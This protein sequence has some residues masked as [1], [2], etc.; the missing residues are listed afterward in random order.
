MFTT[1]NQGEHVMLIAALYLQ[2]LML[3]EDQHS[4][5]NFPA[6]KGISIGQQLNVLEHCF[7]EEVNSGV[8]SP[9]GG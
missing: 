7:L 2:D 9:A 8:W 6:P 3:S 5:T 1:I 4:E